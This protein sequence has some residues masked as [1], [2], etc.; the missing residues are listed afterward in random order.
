MLKH[1]SLLMLDQMLF[2]SLAMPVEMLETAIARHRAVNRSQT[3]RPV[4]ETLGLEK[5]VTPLGGFGIRQDRLISEVTATDLI[6]I[7]ALWR[8]PRKSGAEQREIL[9]WLTSRHAEGAAIMTIGTGAWLPAAAGLL[10][11]Q[12][13]TTHWHALDAFSQRFPQIRLQRDHLLTQSGRIYC[14]ASI[15]SGADLMIHLIGVV[16]GVEIARAVEQQFSPEVRNP[17]EKR[18]FR[19]DAPSHADEEMALVQGYLHQNWQSSLDSS[20]LA[21]LAGLSER[22]LLRR[23]RKA[24]GTAPGLYLQQLKCRHAREWLQSSDLDITEIA[25]LCGFA[26]SSHFVRTFRQQSGVTPGQY[27]KQVRAKLFS[28][29]KTQT[30]GHS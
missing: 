15:N 2:S 11:G 7:P 23:F 20:R 28:V 30:D 25:Q 29:D 10:D 16:F 1:V 19:A 3:V 14:A 6:L 8:N 24:T 5:R 26:D 27:R 22:Q 9:D 17:F 4:I 13:T 12:A 18:V 21:E